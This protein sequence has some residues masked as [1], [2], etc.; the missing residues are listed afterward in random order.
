MSTSTM[1]LA[2]LKTVACIHLGALVLQPVLA[3][4]Y[5]GGDPD[6]MSIHGPVG[7]TAAWLALTQVLLAFLCYLHKRLSG[8]AVAAFATIF[9]LDGLQVHL[10]HA[11]SLAIHIPLGASVLALSLA[12][13]LWLLRHGASGEAGKEEDATRQ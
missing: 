2:A 13:T 4:Q 9:A 7:E 5:F 12:L 1:F 11:K 6:A 8:L 3:G 10:G